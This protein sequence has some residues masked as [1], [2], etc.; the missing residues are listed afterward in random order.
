MTS[1]LAR[2][3]FIDGAEQA[4]VRTVEIPEP[5]PDEL[6]L[7]VHHVGICG[8]DLHYYYQGANGEFVVRE[9]LILGHEL[10]GTVDHDP[11]GALPAGTPVTVHPARFGTED[12]RLAGSPQLWPDGSYL[13]SASTWP[14]TQGALSELLIVDRQMIRV[15]PAS[16][17]IR[18][19]VLA[20]PLAVA[21]HA[22]EQARRAGARIDGARVLVSGSG[23]VGLL[24]VA[25]L[26]AAGATDITATDVLPGPRARMRQQGATHTIDASREDLPRSAYDL[27]MECSGA[28]AAVN[29]V[30]TAVRPAGV[31]AQVGMVPGVPQPVD[32]A[33][34][35]AKEVRFIGA[36]RFAEEIDA[37]VDLLAR[38]PE[39]EAVITHELTPDDPESL[40]GAARDAETSGKVIT[41]PWDQ[42]AR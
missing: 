21:L 41:A 30:L 7:R 26:R 8:S 42:H 35:I 18:R 24:A 20:E 6:R 31:V 4:A 5:G 28:I 23:P 17:P 19:A 40:F 15:L 34:F 16:L 11:T 32:L 36:F 14:H 9:S 13:G 3:L 38:R 29:A 12:P 27:V 10:A 25:A 22:V 37:A 33:P 39:I 1:T 2:A